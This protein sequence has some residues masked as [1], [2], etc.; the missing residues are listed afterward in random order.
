[1]DLSMDD[2]PPGFESSHITNLFY[3]GPGIAAGEHVQSHLFD[4][5]CPACGETDQVTVLSSEWSVSIINGDARGIF[6]AICTA[7]NKTFS[8]GFDD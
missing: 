2:Y 7:C 8:G 1:M 5:R 4:F 6:K 3:R